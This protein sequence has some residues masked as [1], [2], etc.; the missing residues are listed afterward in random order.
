MMI[1]TC[2]PQ[3]GNK[4]NSTMFIQFCARYF[5]KIQ[6]KDTFQKYLEDSFALLINCSRIERKLGLF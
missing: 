5:L 1:R 4:H 3:I 2:A 6:D